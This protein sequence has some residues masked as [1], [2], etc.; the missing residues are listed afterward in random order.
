MIILYYIK[1]K[2]RI[3]VDRFFNINRHLSNPIRQFRKFTYE[4]SVDSTNKL[5]WLILLTDD[6]NL[7]LMLSDKL[8][9]Y[10]ELL[11]KHLPCKY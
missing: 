9:C 6:F 8:K 5:V 10:F 1:K 2:K 11:I 3:K 4:A 7:R